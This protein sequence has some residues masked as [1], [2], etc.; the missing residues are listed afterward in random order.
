MSTPEERLNTANAD[1]AEAEARKASIEADSAARDLAVDLDPEL[2]RRKQEAEAEKAIAEAKKATADAD[3]ARVSA[4]I[5]DL[6]DV[7]KGQ[8]TVTTEQAMF[9]SVLAHRALEDAAVSVKGKLEG[10]LG[11]GVILLTADADLATSD[12]V[13]I[14][15]KT[16]LDQLISTADKLLEEA[17][18]EDV[19]DEAAAEALGKEALGVGVAAA[20]GAA[21]GGPAAVA[22]AVA[23]AVPSVMSLL[24]ANRSVSTYTSTV[25][26]IAA[27]AAVAGALSGAKVLLDD[28]RLVPE[29]GVT[30][31]L[32]DL[33]TGRTSLVDR[34]LNLDQTR[35]Q[36]ST[37]RAA[38]EERIREL[39]T[40]LDKAREKKEST[41]GILQ[42][43]KEEQE[44]RNAASATE[45]RTA[46]LVGL[47]DSVLSTIDAFTIRLTTVATGG[48]RSPL[49]AAALREQ[50]RANG[51]GGISRVLLVK[52]AAG[53]VTQLTNDRPLWFKDKFTVIGNISLS[54]VLINP[55]DSLVM[56]AGEAGGAASMQG[57]IG[58]KLRFQI[59]RDAN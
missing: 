59:E 58:D 10:K 16:G 35:S 4:L 9:S 44:A 54:F 15:V 17:K 36:A 18:P 45:K 52:V 48:K 34:K 30:H 8:T 26:D 39:N 28:F 2:E 42:D 21:A 38:A 47:I 11:D 33:Q 25:D 49:A 40:E 51:N 7:A 50:L 20:L 14:D 43:I 1:K 31:K 24:A 56:G 57:T 27:L 53:S 41:E 32:S 37:R 29:G 55:K 5:P 22:G 12:A 46:V 23:A 19:V 6:K 3:R 13:Y